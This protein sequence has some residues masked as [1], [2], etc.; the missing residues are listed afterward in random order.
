[1]ND[2]FKWLLCA[3]LLL[4]GWVLGFLMGDH[5]APSAAI[6]PAVT[7]PVVHA[8]AEATAPVPLAPASAP[9]DAERTSGRSAEEELRAESSLASLL[10]TPNEFQRAHDLYEAVSKMTPEEIAAAI[11]TAQRLPA[12][13]R[14]VL[15]PMLA[16]RWAES[17]PR[18]AAQFALNFSDRN[19][20]YAV[21]R[22]AL[23]VWAATDSQAALAWA[24]ALPP[25]EQRSNAI[26]GV[27]NALAKRDPASAMQV[28]GTLPKDR[29]SENAYCYDLQR[30]GRAGCAG[31]REPRARAAARAKPRPG[32]SLQH[33]PVGADES[34]GSAGVGEPDS[35]SRRAQ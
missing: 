7:P 3:A 31:R 22:A 35:R 21:S 25:G 19:V 13:D 27:I 4:G 8:S 16:A 11:T 2:K 14:N 23:S 10:R 20:G 1:M 29:N 6:S 15:L 28:L 33:L 12:Q 24:Q 5:A 30:M 34:A 26:Y 9:L 32:H 17:D 18:A